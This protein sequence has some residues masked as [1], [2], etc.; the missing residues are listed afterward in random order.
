MRILGEPDQEHS[1]RNELEKKICE[2]LRRR[3][4]QDISDLKTREEYRDYYFDENEKPI[5]PGYDYVVK[6]ST[7]HK[8][9][10]CKGLS[11]GVDVAGSDL[12]IDEIG[13]WIT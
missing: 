4:G 5:D 1:P 8:D 3:T 13:G 11:F 6:T 7:K 10:Y 9:W 2:E 12:Q